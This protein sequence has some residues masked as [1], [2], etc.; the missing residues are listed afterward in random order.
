MSGG[1]MGLLC[2]KWV[3]SGAVEDKYLCFL[4]WAFTHLYIYSQH[5]YLLKHILDPSL[6][7]HLS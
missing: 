1:K 3:C 2:G 6:S 7:L 4:R 5:L